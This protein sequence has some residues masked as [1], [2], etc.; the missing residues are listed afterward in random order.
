M[1]INNIHIRSKEKILLIYIALTLVTLAVFWQVNQYDFVNIDDAVYVT[2]ND[3]VKQGI[4]LNGFYWIFSTTY[5]EFK[6]YS[7]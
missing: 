6:P 3:H 1:L 7:W 2:G 5:A 4:T